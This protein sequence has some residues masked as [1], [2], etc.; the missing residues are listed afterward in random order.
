[1]RGL[2]SPAFANNYTVIGTPAIAT[3]TIVGVAPDAIVSG[4]TGTPEIEISKDG[5][6]HMED[7]APTDVGAAGA[8]AAGSVKSLWQA[9]LIAIRL[10]VR[11][12]WGKLNPDA[13]QMV[14]GVSW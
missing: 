4:F 5:A 13:V 14:T 9:N 10:R 12:A 7:A 11:C 6:I 8:I 1:M 2:L 3:G